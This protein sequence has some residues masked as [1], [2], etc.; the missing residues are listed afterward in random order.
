LLAA[1]LAHEV[2]QFGFFGSFGNSGNYISSVSSFPPCFKVLDLS[3]G[4]RRSC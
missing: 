3:P 2:F 1:F 4:F